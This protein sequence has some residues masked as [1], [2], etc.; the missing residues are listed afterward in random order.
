MGMRATMRRIVTAHRKIE[1]FLWREHLAIGEALGYEEDEIP[2]PIFGATGLENYAEMASAFS[3]ALDRGLPWKYYL[4]NGM[5]LHFDTVLEQAQFEEEL[6]VND[7]LEKRGAPTQ[8]SPDAG[9]PFG[10]PNPNPND[11]SDE[12]GRTPSGGLTY[13]GDMQEDYDNMRRL[14]GDR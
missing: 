7:L 6:A 3:Q 10:D 12:P 2:K 9:K 13:G 4:E 14:T 8:V 5:G 11:T 1:E